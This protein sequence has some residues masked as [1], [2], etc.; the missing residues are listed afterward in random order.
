MELRSKHQVVQSSVDLVA[1]VLVVV[2]R[3]K[4]KVIGVDQVEDQKLKLVAVEEV[5]VW[6][7]LLE[8]VD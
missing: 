5:G 3:Q 6:V 4:E 1:A 8:V 7:S 2:E